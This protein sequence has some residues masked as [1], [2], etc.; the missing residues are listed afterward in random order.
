MKGIR[1]LDTGVTD[2][3]PGHASDVASMHRE[4]QKQTASF[5]PA[6]APLRGTTELTQADRHSAHLRKRRQR[7]ASRKEADRRL[8]VMARFDEGARRKVEKGKVLQ[9]LAG[10]KQV[11]VVKQQ[12]GGQQQKRGKWKHDLTATLAADKNKK[13]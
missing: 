12:A 7:K 3:V 13:K 5:N 1:S 2:V 4:E 9:T 10:S 6:K 8:H 11:T